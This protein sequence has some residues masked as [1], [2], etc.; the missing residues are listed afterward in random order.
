MSSLRCSWRWFLAQG[1]S[2]RMMTL[3]G[4]K[5]PSAAK[6][7]IATHNDKMSSSTARIT[8]AV[9]HAFRWP[10]SAAS[11]ASSRTS[12]H[13]ISVGGYE[14]GF[15]GAVLRFAVRRGGVLGGYVCFSPG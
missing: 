4:W 7:I 14:T 9:R 2:L 15:G 1:L 3:G 12:C 11:E 6:R 10:H 13:A 8:A 5:S